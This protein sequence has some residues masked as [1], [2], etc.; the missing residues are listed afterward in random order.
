MK[1]RLLLLALVTTLLMTGCITPGYDYRGDGYY[2][3]GT[4]VEYR[5]NRGYPYGYY[6]DYYRYGYPYS[7]GPSYRYGPSY[8]YPYRYDRYYGYPGPYRYRHVYPRAGHRYDY[9]GHQRPPSSHTGGGKPPWRDL[10][11]MRQ[12][13]GGQPMRPPRSSP[14]V[15]GSAPRV[16]SPAPSP[17]ASESSPAAA[18]RRAEGRR[19]RAEMKSGER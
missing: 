3:G 17:R 9:P 13:E 6:D 2:Y 12:A 5:S 11:R 14:P 8:G 1:F 10:G 19:A 7:Y 18:Q 15:S 4:R 16:Y